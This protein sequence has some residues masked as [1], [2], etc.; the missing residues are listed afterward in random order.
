MTFEDTMDQF[1]TRNCYYEPERRRVKAWPAYQLA[2][3]ERDAV[4]AQEIA[5]RVL[6]TVSPPDKAGSGNQLV[7]SAHGIM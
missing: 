5:T 3:E 1:F 4:L 2:A 7:P 6:E